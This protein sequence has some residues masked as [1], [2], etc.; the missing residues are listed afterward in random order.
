MVLDFLPTVQLRVHNVQ[1]ER[2]SRNTCALVNLYLLSKLNYH[3]M[4]F[5]LVVTTVCAGGVAVGA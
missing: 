2:K 5:F 1:S 3:V 4:P